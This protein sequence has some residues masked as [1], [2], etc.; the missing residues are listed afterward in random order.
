MADV[1]FIKTSSLGDVIHHLPAL[2]EARAR[3]PDV[4][5]QWVVEEAYAPLARLHPAVAR[6]IPV[7]WRRWRHTLH[8]RQTRREMAAFCR[9]LR[10]SAFDDI[11]DTQGLIRT[12]LIAR[13]ARGRRHGYDAA[14]IKERP[15]AWFYDVRHAVSR[16]LHAIERNRL[17]T[18]HALGYVIGGEADY[19][20]DRSR[21]VTATSRYGVLLHGTARPEKQWPVEHWRAL[22]QI[23]AR[24]IDLVV[25]FGTAEERRRSE[26]ITAGIGRASVPDFQPLDEIARTI[27]GAS[28][29]VGVDTGLLHL[30]AALGV[31]LVALYSHSDPKLTGPCGSGPIKLLHAGGQ[32]PSAKEVA[33]AVHE[34]L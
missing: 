27:A 30:A 15:A 14:S 32:T 19:G 1:L 23:L 6:V 34:I 33:A 17:L 20:L 16:S 29:V 18:A 9:E 12:G 3:C 28:F 7:A 10:G 5:F 21:L 13:L 24:E 31:P 25:P 4:R 8:R 26:R 2:T 22:A 11:I